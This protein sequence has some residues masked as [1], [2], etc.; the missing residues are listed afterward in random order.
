VGKETYRDIQRKRQI[1]AYRKRY[2]IDRGIQK[3][4]HN[5]LVGKEDIYRERDIQKYKVTVR[6]KKGEGE[7]GKERGGERALRIFLKCCNF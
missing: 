5:E 4:V 2:K 7:R 6:R 3:K 1:E